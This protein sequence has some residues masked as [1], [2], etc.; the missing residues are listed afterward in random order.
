MYIFKHSHLIISHRAELVFCYHICR[1]RLRCHHPQGLRP[2]AFGW[3]LVLHLAA[4]WDLSWNGRRCTAL[5][6]TPH[7]WTQGYLQTQNTPGRG[8]KNNILNLEFLLSPGD[9]NVVIK[10][11]ISEIVFVA[12]LIT[13]EWKK[14]L[15]SLYVHT[16]EKAAWLLNRKWSKSLLSRVIRWHFDLIILLKFSKEETAEGERFQNTCLKIPQ[17]SMLVTGYLWQ[18]QSVSGRERSKFTTL[19][20]LADTRFQNFLS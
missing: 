2:P 20:T 15:C 6:N 10:Y 5:E 1:A 8:K 16:K 14:V 18:H 4:S 9:V 12:C 17:A 13:Q 19:L 11:S 7:I 3:R